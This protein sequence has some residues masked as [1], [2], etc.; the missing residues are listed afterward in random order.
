MDI[1]IGRDMDEHE[2]RVVAYQ[3]AS[4]SATISAP[5]IYRAESYLCENLPIPALVSLAC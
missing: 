1:Y 5:A 4:A 3:I 2:A